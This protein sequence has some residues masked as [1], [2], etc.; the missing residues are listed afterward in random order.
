[1]QIQG[2]DSPLKATLQAWLT[3]EG[4]STSGAAPT[5]VTGPH[6]GMDESGKGDWFGPL[7]VAAVY[8]DEQTA[9]ALRKAGVRDSKTL[10]P[11]AI[12]RI[13]GQIERIVPP[14]RRHV[15]AI[16]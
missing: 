16:E 8:V 14:D 13:A 9:A 4:G 10:P 15:W 5:A 6:I 11:A 1:M 7:V 2:P 12:Q 3:G